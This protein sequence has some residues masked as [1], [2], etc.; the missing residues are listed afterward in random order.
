M[1]IILFAL[2]LSLL[3]IGAEALVRGASRMAAALGISPLVI[4]LTVVALGTS[5]PE[6]A[7][8]IKSTLSGQP[9]IALG[10]IIGSNISNILLIIGLSALILPLSISQQLIRLDVPLMIILSVVVLL[11]SVDHSIG[12][13]DGLLLVT[14][15]VFYISFLIWHN[16]K[17]NAE[18]AA[19]QTKESI[20][21]VSVNTHWIKNIGLFAGGLLL[22]FIGSRWLISSAI[23]IARY[24]GVSE[25]VIGLTIIAAGTSLPEAVTSV[26]AAIRGERDIAVGNVVGSN[27]L[28]IMGVL[29]ITGLVA[30]G[31]IEVSDAVIGFDLP[32]MIVVALACLPIFFSG[33]SISRLEGAFLLGYYFIYNA[34]LILSA[35]QHDALPVF[36]NVMLYFLIPFT[37]SIMIIVTTQEIRKSKNC[38]P[39]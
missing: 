39:E 9:G 32:V 35:A 22:L 18:I 12:R 21:E 27:I 33:C 7:V 25:L 24:L 8:S 23:S 28:N 38:Q 3:I 14:G 37:V 17:E 29:G 5:S 26:I 36:S 15:L 6:L 11:L 16:R 13:S 30:P 2:G 19:K 34:Y 1:T 20:I 10:N 4:G 31:G